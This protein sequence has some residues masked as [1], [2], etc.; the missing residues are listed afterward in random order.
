MLV[1]ARLR[2]Q[3]LVIGHDITVTVTDIRGDKVRLGIAAPRNVSVHRKEIY[4]QIMEENRRAARLTPHDVS[5]L[6][7]VPTPPAQPLAILFCWQ[8]SK[9]RGAASKAA[10]CPMAR[11]WCAT[12]RLSVE[13]TTDAFSRMIRW[14]MLRSNA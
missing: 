8:P 2:N 6:A 9:R 3:S 1:L 13:D 14:R 11:F 10:D 5:A 12:I 7:Q 4:D